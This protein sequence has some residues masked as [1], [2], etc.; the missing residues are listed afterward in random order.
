MSKRDYYEVLGVP[1]TASADEIKRAFRK[2]AVQYHPDKSDGDE[3]KF[4]EVN[5][6][7]E[8]LKDQQKRARYDQ[9]GHAGYDGS[10]AGGGQSYGGNP[11]EGFGGFAGGAGAGFDFSDIF[12]QFFGGAAGGAGRQTRGQDLEVETTISFKESVFGTEQEV[13]ATVDETCPH[14]H[15]DGAEPGTKLDTCPDC[16]GSGKQTRVM[17]SLFGQVQQQIMC[18]TCDGRGKVPEEKCHVCHGKGVQRGRQSLTV[19]IPAGIE[20]GA[21]IRLS[22]RGEALAGG[23]PGDLY[24]HVRVQPD[25]RFTRDGDTI[26]SEQKISMV[27]AAL[28]TEIDV[29]T[30]DGEVTMRVPAGTQ[31]GTDFRLANY[32]VKHPRGDKRG[33]HVVRLTVEI[34]KRLNK[35]QRQLLEDFR[36]IK[37]GLFS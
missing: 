34:P 35:Q 3:A 27:D 1:K 36:D 22:G 15:G 7:Y 4:K 19:K 14:C 26:F 24:I 32:G 5:E 33:A 31:S 9:F 13:A 10:Q 28:G 21:V 2:K 25:K 6:A 12:G 16:Q 37:G 30:I 17:N 20:D 23:E 11:F 18:P 29:L 8:V